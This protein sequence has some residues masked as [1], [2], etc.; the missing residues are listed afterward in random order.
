MCAD[1]LITD[2]SMPDVSGLDFVEGQLR[3]GCRIPNIAIMSGAW[4]DV[5][6]KRAKDLGCASFEK[7]VALSALAD[8]LDKCEERMDKNKELSNWFIQEESNRSS[9]AQSDLPGM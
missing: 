7:P 4:S 9:S 3:K 6:M 2:I 1:I 8:W 5:S